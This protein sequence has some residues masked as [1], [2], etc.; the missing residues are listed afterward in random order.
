MEIS[1]AAEFILWYLAF[2]IS[3]TFHEAAHSLASLKMGDKTAYNAGQVTLNPIPHI[4]REPL[5][6]ILVPI[7]TFAVGGW[8]V[9]YT[10]LTLPTKVSV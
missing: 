7:I 5:G 10:H 8:T 2:I 4:K 9:S 3:I 6:T 1:Q